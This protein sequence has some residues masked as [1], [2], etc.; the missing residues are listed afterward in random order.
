[1]N[2]VDYD[3]ADKEKAYTE[4]RKMALEKARQKAEDMAKIA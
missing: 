2:G 4:A 1:M 3:L